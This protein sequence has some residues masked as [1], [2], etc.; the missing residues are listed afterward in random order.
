MV[1][2]GHAGVLVDG[3]AVELDLQGFGR[4]IVAD[5]FQVGGFDGFSN[6]GILQKATE[7]TQQ[8]S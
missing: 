5:A 6:H 7:R 8:T 2:A 1:A 4:G 3:A